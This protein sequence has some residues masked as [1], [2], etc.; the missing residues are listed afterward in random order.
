MMFFDVFQDLA[1]S[2]SIKSATIIDAS[3]KKSFMCL[4][5]QLPIMI[6]SQALLLDNWMAFSSAFL[7]I[8]IR[9]MKLGY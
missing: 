2:S 7:S 1:A 6:K 9:R 8:P 3:Q 4:K 5:P